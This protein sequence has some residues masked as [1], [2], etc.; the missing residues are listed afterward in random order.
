MVLYDTVLMSASGLAAAAQCNA[1][2]L[3]RN[4][5]ACRG[6]AGRSI[7]CS[8]I[9]SPWPPPFPFALNSERFGPP[10][11][12]TSSSLLHVLFDLFAVLAS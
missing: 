11:T 6:R 12:Q 3:S 7:L 5:A 1:A 2:A 10:G 4:A 8:R 9:I